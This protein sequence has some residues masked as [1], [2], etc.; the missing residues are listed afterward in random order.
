MQ[1]QNEKIEIINCVLPADTYHQPTVNKQDIDTEMIDLKHSILNLNEDCLRQ[2]FECCDL[3]TLVNLSEV[4]QRFHEI[5][6]RTQFP[7]FKAIT[8]NLNRDQKMNVCKVRRILRCIGPYLCDIT[9]EAYYNE[10]FENLIRY[11]HKI[12]Q[13]VGTNMRQLCMNQILPVPELLN[14]INGI[15]R[16]IEILKIVVY[17]GDF[18]FDIDFRTLCPNL[19]KLKLL[20]NAQFVEN[21]GKWNKLRNLSV[22]HNEFMVSSTFISFMENNPLLNSLKV[23]AYS[24]DTT[25]K[26]IGRCLPNLEKLTLYQGFPDISSANL[27]YLLQLKQLTTLKLMYLD[28]DKLNDV[29]DCLSKFKGLRKLKLHLFYDGPSDEEHYLPNQSLLINIAQELNQ[30]ETFHIYRCQLNAATVIDFIRYA[31]NLKEF[32]WHECDTQLTKKL[33]M[34]IVSIMKEKQ[35]YT[36]KEKQ[37][38]ILNIFVDRINGGENVIKVRVASIV[39]IY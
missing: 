20:Q 29:L 23:T 31:E 12:G 4:C 13:Y 8:F 37:R 35:L 24:S 3:E 6:H 9:I 5:L 18:D 15:L 19:I 33:L 26:E 17:N 10:K 14:G 2:I 16:R 1:S 7:K 28:E 30:L 25:V 34:D 32:H 27:V 22:I 36:S 21:A 38:Q 39:L 11:F